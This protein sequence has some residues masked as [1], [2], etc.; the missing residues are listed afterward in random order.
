[1][2]NTAIRV[3][4]KANE[5]YKKTGIHQAVVELDDGEGRCVRIVPLGYVNSDE[6]E[7]FEGSVIYQT[8]DNE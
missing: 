4:A 8:D 7:A 1:M 3:I 2:L 5:L 6:Y